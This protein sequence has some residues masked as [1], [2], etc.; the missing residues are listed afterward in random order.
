MNSFLWENRPARVCSP[1][2]ILE[3]NVP[4]YLNLLSLLVICIHRKINLKPNY[5]LSVSI[6]IERTPV[7]VLLVNSNFSGL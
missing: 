3:T 2:S 1:P 6:A 5:L 4:L 7:C